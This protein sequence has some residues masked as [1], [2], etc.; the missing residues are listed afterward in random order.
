MIDELN[1]SFGHL[2][3]EKEELIKLLNDK[4]EYNNKLDEKHK[5]EIEEINDKI[6]KGLNKI[7]N[8]YKKGIDDF[9]KKI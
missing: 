4:H 8:Q 9:Y 6:K 7:D 5:K 2:N 3:K 1:A